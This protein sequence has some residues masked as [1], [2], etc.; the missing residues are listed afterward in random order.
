MLKSLELFGFKSFADKTRFD[1]SAGI[2]G[3]VGPNGSG[4]SNVVDGIK[5][6]LGDQSA[7]S[8]R[9]KEMTD[10]IFN[11]ALGRKPS[12]FSEA[13]LIFDN[14]ARYLPVD[15][16][17]VAIGRRLWRSGD[18]EY[19]IN[20]NTSRLKD[21]RDILMGTGVG[22][23]AYCIIEQGRVDQI[24]Q[25][26]PT[27]R[28]KVFEEAAGVARF[29]S[30]RMEAERKLERV[31]Q[32]LLRLTDI[33]EEV[34]S[35]LNSIRTQAAKASKFRKYSEELKETWLGLAA[36]EFRHMKR[37]TADAELAVER[38]T[39]EIADLNT[40]QQALETRIASLD[41]EINQL[42][43][44]LRAVEGLSSTHREEMATHDSTVRHLTVRLREFDLE[45]VRL[46]KQQSTMTA[47][48]AAAQRESAR[49]ATK[50]DEHDQV[51]RKL[52]EELTTSETR[53]ETFDS[54]LDEARRAIGKRRDEF[55]QAT[56]AASQANINISTW[57]HKQES[58][59]SARE[60]IAGRIADCD[61]RVES[62]EGKQKTAQLEL[63]AAIVEFTVAEERVRELQHNRNS[64][65]GKQGSSQKT[66]AELREERSA[67]LARK[68]LLEDLEYRQEGLGIGVREILK[69][70]ETSRYS[71][72]KDI[73]GSVA[74][75]LEVDLEQAPLVD[76]ALGERA[77]LLVI[78]D[79]APLIEY[80]NSGACN[81]AGRVGFVTPEGRTLRIPESSARDQVTRQQVEL[82]PPQVDHAE[83]GTT[84]TRT[85][86]TTEA[87]AAEQNSNDNPESVLDL[88][89]APG[90]VKR[91]DQL[92][93]SPS[94]APQ[95]AET[96]LSETWIVDTLDSAL[97]LANGNHAGCRFVTLQGETVESDGTLF[98][99]SVRAESAIV[100]R[101]SELRRLKVDLGRLEKMIQDKQQNLEVLGNTLSETDVAIAT[102]ESQ[103]Q[104]RLENLTEFKSSVAAHMKELDRLHQERVQLTEEQQVIDDEIQLAAHELESL[105]QLAETTQW[106]IEEARERIQ[107]AEQGL[108]TLEQERQDL[109]YGRAE[110]RLTLAKQ[111]ERVIA[112]KNARQRFS[113]EHQQ[114]ALQASEAGDR[115][116]NTLADRSSATLQLL[117]ARSEFSL[118]CWRKE[119]VDSSIRDLMERRRDIRNQR[120]Q[121]NERDIQTRQRRRAL[122]DELHQF[123]IQVRDVQHQVRSLGER[124][125]EE[126]QEPLEAI[127]ESGA[128]AF[129]IYLDKK[130]PN[131]DRPPE[132]ETPQTDLESLAADSET[133]LTEESLAPDSQPPEQELQDGEVADGELQSG[134]RQNE[135]SHGEELHE[136]GA[137]PVGD[138]DSNTEMV[139]TAEITEPDLS[140][141]DIE[142]EPEPPVAFADVRGEIEA[143][144]NALRRKIRN[145]G[146]VSSESLNNLEQLESRFSHL[147]EHLQDLVEAKQTLED[148]VRRIN[149][150]SRKMFAETFDEIRGHF[151]TLFRKLFGG[152]EG[153][154]ILEDPEDILECGIDVVARPPGKEL[155]SIS[156]LSGGE[157]TMTAVALLLA[158]FKSR[159]SPFCILDEVDA[160]LD[161]A[162][163]DRFVGVLKDFQDTTQ[164]IMITHRK[165]SM[166]ATD[167]LYGVTMEQ[168]GVSKRMAVRFEDVSDDGNFQTSDP[169]ASEELKQAA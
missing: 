141:A 35:Q 115:L 137:I 23:S 58:S 59:V 145:L 1:F 93:R 79:I 143:R 71:P 34:E 9:G 104:A 165:P 135:E 164:F 7:K 5:W 163:V 131:W 61:Q 94:V 22:T 49:E 12:S 112:S 148:I 60:S 159:P 125:E 134:E 68:S 18:S 120:A 128:S 105:Q 40:E 14:T 32:N 64:L 103:L 77:Q 91:A 78:R 74:D 133:E 50:L 153:D 72:W 16:E 110:R 161:E 95:L 89:D 126:Y 139:D 122:S 43:D 100:S 8:L 117:N 17:E 88:S 45:I 54:E 150:E 27:N 96:L 166:A 46:R 168:S 83:T 107:D 87:E 111:E 108:E 21:I 98:V 26:N 162:N 92:V 52:T 129:R 154:I 82:E 169:P 25:S 158:M 65:L 75:L 28:R 42:D 146:N 70:A 63:D 62:V 55:V 152:G 10:V 81:I 41:V 19:L 56:E 90:I 6:L 118:H 130:F 119:A 48:A 86:A 123:E 29:K 101:K 67:A 73:V 138:P 116:Q 33:V 147:S 149:H 76:I 53:L 140:P 2:T 36:D 66:L 142:V 127:V 97:V 85:A 38:L 44:E 102:S 20:G 160:A 39:G 132:S 106:A 124:I 11:G 69:R 37:Q 80:L 47:R 3:V 155:R 136:S 151:Q 121:L 109:E 114:H 99:G 13:T 4:K 167:V 24:L 15:S 31:Q 51:F 30:R 156:L 84:E 113:D 144:V 57:K 157:K